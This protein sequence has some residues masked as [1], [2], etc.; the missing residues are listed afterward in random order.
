MRFA[1]ALRFDIRFQVKARVFMLSMRGHQCISGVARASGAVRDVLLPVV[2]HSSR[3]ARLIFTG[4]LSFWKGRAD[5]GESLFVTPLRSGDLARGLL[6]LG[7]L[8]VSTVP[9]CGWGDR[10]AARPIFS[11]RRP[12][13]GRDL[14]PAG[15]RGGCPGA[16][17][18]RVISRRPSH[19]ARLRA[20]VDHFGWALAPL[21]TFSLPGLRCC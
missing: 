18:Q 20:L 4:R 8:S 5:F 2:L 14:H 12:A 17:L 11:F 6:S 16:Q 7:L 15:F 21:L 1:A 19:A 9:R 13:H 10:Q 3:A